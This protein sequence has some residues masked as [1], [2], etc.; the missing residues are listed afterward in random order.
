MTDV[1][2]VLHSLYSIHFD[3][4]KDFPT[5]PESFEIGVDAEIGPSSAPGSER[6]T[7]YICTPEWLSRMTSKGHHVWGRHRLIVERW[8]RGLVYGAIEGLCHRLH[9]DDWEALANLLAEYGARESTII[10]R[11][12]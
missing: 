6:F 11:Q 4:D 5:D 3:V 2:P 10:E 12:S 7:F 1:T 9:A 8:D